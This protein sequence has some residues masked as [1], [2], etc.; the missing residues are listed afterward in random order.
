MHKKITYLVCSLFLTTLFF[1][2]CSKNDPAVNNPDPCAGKNIVVT[3]TIT[4]SASPTSNNGAINAAASGSSGFTFRINNGTYQASGVF[5]N[6]APGDYTVEAKDADGCTKSQSFTV[7]A[8][9]CPTIT[10]TATITNS[11]GTTATDGAIVAAASGSTGFTYSISGGAFQASSTFNNLVTGSYVV[12]AKDG[13]GCTGSGTFVVAS[14]GCPT[15][16]V[17]GTS[18]PTAG[19]SATNGTISSNASGGTSPYTYSIDGGTTFVGSGNFS[20]L[21]GG[22]YTIVAK[23]ANNC[24]G[25]S[26]SIN[27]GVAACPTITVNA[28]VTGSDKC[29]NN[30][31]TIT[32]NASGST[33]FQYRLNSGAFQASNQFTQL[34]TGN[35]TISARDVNGCIASNTTNLPIATAGAKFSAVKSIMLASCATSGCHSGSSPQSGINLSDDCTIVN[36]SNRIKIRSVD[37]TPSFMP[38]GGGQLSA[39]DKQKIVD[40][41]NAGGQHS[42]N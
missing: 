29:T 8:S 28:A 5:A 2:S 18:T 37:G 7:T 42:N 31:G 24:L 12:T 40:W 34:A 39:A 27:V 33:G 35:F 11:S 22:N 1:L 38:P 41:I 3:A 30:T 26:G 9:A 6:L 20:G 19:P 23:D 17:T 10:V 21:A 13:N 16:T 14:A 15:I 25:S 36:Q 32:I 4:P